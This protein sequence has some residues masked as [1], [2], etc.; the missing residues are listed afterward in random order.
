MIA[1]EKREKSTTALSHGRIFDVR[2][3]DTAGPPFD[4]L[5]SWQHPSQ[6]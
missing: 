4:S 3:G 6:G 2:K 1:P 5:L